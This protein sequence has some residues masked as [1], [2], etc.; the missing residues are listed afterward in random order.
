MSSEVM[1]NSNSMLIKAKKEKSSEDSS[2]L[3]ISFDNRSLSCLVG[4][5][6][7]EG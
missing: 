4:W 2:I 5:G 7:A 3:A 1:I 6:S